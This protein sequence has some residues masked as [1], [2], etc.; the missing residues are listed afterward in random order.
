MN[1]L[2]PPILAA[3]SAAPLPDAGAGAA[4][5]VRGF[6]EHVRS[7]ER[8]ELADRYMAA[9][10]K[11]HQLTSEG[12]ETIVRTPADYAEHVR[13]FRRMFG[14]FRLSVQEILADGDRVYVRWH[15]RGRHLASVD[16]EQP[17]GKQLNEI[18]SAV[19]R[20]SQGH[21]VEYWIQTDRK[22]LELQL[23]RADE[24]GR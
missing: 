17:T 4:E 24:Q 16:G 19:Y 15:Q 12:P 20:V 10:V 6:I 13:D 14:S 9:K 2:I 18:S 23:A 22:G 5:L 1:A 11:A 7:G 21:I 3:I 8:P